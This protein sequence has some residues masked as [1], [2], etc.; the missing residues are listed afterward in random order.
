MSFSAPWI[1]RNG[2]GGISK[3][4]RF[5]AGRWQKEFVDCNTHQDNTIFAFNADS[6]AAKKLGKDVI[7]LMLP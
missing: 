3:R 4:Q 7:Q 2:I 1:A 5:E 6:S